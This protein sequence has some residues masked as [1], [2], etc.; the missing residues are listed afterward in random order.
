MWLFFMKKYRLEFCAVKVLAFFCFVL[1]YCDIT[2][3][4][5]EKQSHYTS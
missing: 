3:E 1:Y 4:K 2:G 5:N